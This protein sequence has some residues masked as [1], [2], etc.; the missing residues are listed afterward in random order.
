MSDRERAPYESNGPAPLPGDRVGWV[1]ASG[2]LHIVTMPDGEPKPAPAE[3]LSKLLPP[4]AIAVSLAEQE[5][6]AAIRACSVELDV[7]RGHMRRS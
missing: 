6:Q 3:V 5:H 1:D 7:E 2:E 4:M